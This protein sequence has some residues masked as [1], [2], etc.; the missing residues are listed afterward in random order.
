MR[1]TKP[2]R[3]Q[4]DKFSDILSDIGLISLASV[5]LPA[6]FDRYDPE[7]LLLGVLIIWFISLRLKR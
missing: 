7:R 1:I 5:V 6:I 4:S 2:S 3:R